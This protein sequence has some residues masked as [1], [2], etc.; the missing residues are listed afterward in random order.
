M[1]VAFPDQPTDRRRH[2]RKDIRQ[3][4]IL[5][6]GRNV[7]KRPCRF[8]DISEG[9]ARLHV[10]LLI[11]LPNHF[12]LISPVRTVRRECRLIWTAEFEVGI[13]FV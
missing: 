13:E 9:G 4:G 8:K 6:F 2:A 1:F 11:D 3:T 5:D 7:P 10:G 12:L